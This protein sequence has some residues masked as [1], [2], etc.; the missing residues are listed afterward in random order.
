M[1]RI[2]FL[3]MKNNVF[4]TM[5]NYYSLENF[6]GNL[7]C[8][9]VLESINLNRLY[10]C[11]NLFTDDSYHINKSPL[12]AQ[13]LNDVKSDKIIE[14]L[15]AK[16]NNSEGPVSC[17]NIFKRNIELVGTIIEIDRDNHFF[18]A[19][20]EANIDSNKR[21]VRFSFDEISED[22]IDKIVLERRIVYSLIREYVGGEKKN[23]SKIFF[24]DVPV[25]NQYAIKK[26]NEKASYFYKKFIVDEIPNK[27]TRKKR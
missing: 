5:L 1:F 14:S 20:M 10:F 27:S 16:I 12:A 21:N 18:I 19:L 8:D 7:S 24:L 22:D 15:E 11:D 6:S 17:G 4:H 9:E 23:I 13:Q 3:K 26:I 2:A 25:L